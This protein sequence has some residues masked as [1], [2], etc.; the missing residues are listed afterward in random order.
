MLRRNDGGLRTELIYFNLVWNDFPAPSGWNCRF[1]RHK[2]ERK[3]RFNSYRQTFK[4]G[5]YATLARIWVMKVQEPS[6]TGTASWRIIIS[7]PNWML[8]VIGYLGTLGTIY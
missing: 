7:R 4:Y 6:G 5:E 3:E 8:T 1:K 2:D